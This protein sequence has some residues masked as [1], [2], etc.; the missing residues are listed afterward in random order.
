M[1]FK[2]SESRYCDPFST[3]SNS[4]M[5]AVDDEFN[6]TGI[7]DFLAPWLRYGLSTLCIY[8]WLFHDNYTSPLAVADRNLYY[9]VFTTQEAFDS[10][11]KRFESNYLTQQWIGTRLSAP[12]KA[13]IPP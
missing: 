5:Q 11:F 4:T 12:F 13:F 1:A 2:N 9:G 10:R 8:P 6:N 3:I 7:M